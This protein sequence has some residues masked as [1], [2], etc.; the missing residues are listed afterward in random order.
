MN[1]PSFHDKQVSEILNIFSSSLEGL[2]DEDAKRNHE[3][4]GY[5]EL[6]SKDETNLFIKFIKQFNSFLVYILILAIIVSV[7]L[8]KNVDA[9][10]IFAIILFNAVIGFYQEYKAEKSIKALKEMIVPK[11][12]VY[13][14]KELHQLNARELVPGDVILLRGGDKISADGRIIEQNNFV[15]NEAVLTG[16]SLSVHKTSDVFPVDTKIFDQKNMVFMGT[17]VNGGDAKVVVT[18]IGRDTFLGGIA[19]SLEKID[20]HKGL[21]KQKTDKLAF[22][23]GVFSIINASIIFLIGFFIRKFELAQISLFTLASLVSSIPEGLPAVLA[24]VLAVGAHRMSK[25]NAIVRRLSVTETLGH[26]T[27]IATDKTGTIT[28]NS[29]TIEKVFLSNLEEVTVSGSGWEMS[30]NFYKNENQIVPLEDINLR[31]LLHIACMCN[32]SEIIK[33]NGRFSILGDP[34]EASLIAL[35][36]KG[37]LNRNILHSIEKKIDD[38]P[39][40][41]TLRYRA[42]LVEKASNKELYIVGAPETILDL[43]TNYADKNNDFNITSEYRNKILKEI[44]TYGRNA[45]RVLAIGYKKLATDTKEI[46]H[47]NV[48]GITFVGLVCMKDPPKPN[49][50]KAISYAKK[51]GIRIIMKTGD[52]KETAIAIAKEIG[53]VNEDSIN[54]TSQLVLTDED[55]LAMNKEDFSRAVKN[56]SI[57]ARITPQLK[58]RI[59]EELQNQGEIVAMT[60]DGVNDALALKKADIGIAMGQ[61]GTDVAREAS[62]MVLAD[63][64]FSTIISAIKEGRI[65]FRNIKQTTYYLLTTSIAEDLTIISSLILGFP[66]PLLP[67]Q[68]LWLNLVTDG[69]SDVALATE[70]DHGDTLNKLPVSDRTSFLSKDIFPF[71]SIMVITMSVITL[72]VFNQFLDQGIEKARTMAFG[73]MTY[74]Q[75]FNV[76][77]MRSLSKSV[78]QI[79]LFSNKY[80]VGALIFGVFSILILFYHPVVN[81][82]FGFVPLATNEFLMIVFLSSFVLIFGEVYKSFKRKQ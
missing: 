65:V 82:L 77:N 63:D 18:S 19:E 12:Y 66:L 1:K 41:E 43:C 46:S 36:G 53:L 81:K 28:Q 42:S 74:S 26:A 57:F 10:L 44:L 17:F 75:L 72:F 59:V 61:I 58:H 47:V 35:A 2:T 32:D 27:V 11:T 6:P 79:G 7:Y 49:V 5:N 3:V 21:F 51:A 67:T 29:M 80:V 68:I 14:N 38:L 13:R 16:E 60:G 15:T 70:P 20:G 45:Y 78:F 37:S 31:K 4:Y 64:N 24:I 33:S 39:F 71:L 50:A 54:S 40:N 69:I 52:H 55:L 48:S 22:Q 9:Y 73:I 8:Q 23:L 62:E 76:L 56:V 30:G 25:Q 34:T